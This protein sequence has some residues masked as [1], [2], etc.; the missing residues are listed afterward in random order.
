MS[1][2]VVLPE[3][4]VGDGPEAV[5]RVEGTEAARDGEDDDGSWS[6]HAVTASSR[7]AAGTART[8][9]RAGSGIKER[10]GGQAGKGSA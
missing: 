4:V 3:V 10:P 7:A 5:P 6:V 8:R 2:A 9:A 1:M